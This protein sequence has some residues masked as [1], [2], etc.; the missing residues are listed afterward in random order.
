M[1]NCTHLA[2][3]GSTQT[4]SF[5]SWTFDEYGIA[6][7]TTFGWVIRDGTQGESGA[8]SK[9]GVGRLANLGVTL[10][11]RWANVLSDAARQVVIECFLG[12]RLKEHF[13]S[14]A[15]VGEE[16]VPLDESEG[17]LP[18][19]EDGTPVAPGA[20]EEKVGCFWTL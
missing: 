5:C 19:I 10:Q 7:R 13:P 2:W 15:M 3:L 6:T 8:V 9:A 17:D 11:R 18:E 4:P 1:S 20:K 14:L 16:G 12:L